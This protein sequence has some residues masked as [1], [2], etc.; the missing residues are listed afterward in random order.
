M[1]KAPKAPPPIINR[2][3]VPPEKPTQ[4]ALGSEDARNRRLSKDRLGT[5]QL[6]IDL[7]IPGGNTS[8]SVN[9]GG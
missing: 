7:N 5:Q 1:C 4:L 8:G 3:P 9:T 2:P 6:R